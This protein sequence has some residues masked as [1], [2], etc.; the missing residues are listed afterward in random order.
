[1]LIRFDTI[2]WYK[3]SAILFSSHPIMIRLVS[4]AVLLLVSVDA[5]TE[6]YF[7]G[8]LFCKLPKIQYK[9]SIYEEDKNTG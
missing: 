4:F 8:Q 3:F 7:S 6:F 2:G 9:I 1:M 5:L